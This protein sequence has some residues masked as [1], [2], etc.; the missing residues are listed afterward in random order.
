MKCKKLVLV[1]LFFSNVAFSSGIPTVDVGTITNTLE[2]IQEAKNQLDELKEQVQTAKA[3]LDEYKR[4]AIET[5][6][7]LEGFVDYKSIFDDTQKYFTDWTDDFKK[8]LTEEQYAK[9]KN[10]YGIKTENDFLN[11]YFKKQIETIEAI[12]KYTKKLDSESEKLDGLYKSFEDAKT[13]AKRDEIAN[14]IAM[15][16]QK[17]RLTQ[18]KI[19]AERELYQ[20]R[21]NLEAQNRIAVFDMETNKVED[22]NF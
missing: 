10:S 14:T 22:F 4:E 1:G 12:E 2:M 11:D 5:K 17:L 16:E 9:K 18:E 7:R 3:Q 8:I 13:P 20:L 21:S 19:R 6:N 15:Q